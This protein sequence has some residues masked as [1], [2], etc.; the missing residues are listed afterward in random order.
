MK[1]VAKFH[2]GITLIPCITEILDFGGVYLNVIRLKLIKLRGLYF[3][4]K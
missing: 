3:H 2:K 4:L 1:A